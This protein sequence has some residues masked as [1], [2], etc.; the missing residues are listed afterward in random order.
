MCRA[1]WHPRIVRGRTVDRQ[2]FAESFPANQK[3]CLAYLA[4]CAATS[5]LQ[6]L[7]ASIA[8]GH[9]FWVC[10]TGAKSDHSG[11]H[12]PAKQYKKRKQAIHAQYS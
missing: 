2:K 10:E 6:A 7:T 5:I 8:G 11:N 3:N 9:R 12:Q 1:V 4:P